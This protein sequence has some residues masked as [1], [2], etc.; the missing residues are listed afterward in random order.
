V[1]DYLV[2]V[3]QP[4]QVHAWEEESGYWFLYDQI[5]GGSISIQELDANPIIGPANLWN[6]LAGF[7]LNKE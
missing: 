7:Q 3:S 6:H 4:S 1:R 5:F 2:L